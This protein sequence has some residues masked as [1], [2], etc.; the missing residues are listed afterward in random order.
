[1][2]FTLGILSEISERLGGFSAFEALPDGRTAVVFMS[3]TLH[4]ANRRR[5][6]ASACAAWTPLP[7]V[8]RLRPRTQGT[9]TLPRR[10]TE[11]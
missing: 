11:C 8:A 9:P 5:R 7:E 10:S 2:A 1:M 4:P 6:V 3:P